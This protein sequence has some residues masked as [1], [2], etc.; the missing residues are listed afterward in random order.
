MRLVVAAAIENRLAPE[1]SHEQEPGSRP[2]LLARHE[3]G[4]Q[5][6]HVRDVQPAAARD[7]GSGQRV[8]E[9]LVERSS[10]PAIE[11]HGK[12]ALRLHVEIR[13]QQLTAYVHEDALRA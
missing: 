6:F 9:N 10:Q 2:C 11:R 5:S 12:S 13:R 3:A 4:L 7:T 8:E 1:L